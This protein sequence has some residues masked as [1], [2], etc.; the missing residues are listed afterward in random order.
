VRFQL[1]L[2]TSGQNKFRPK[3]RPQVTM[4]FPYVPPLDPP[5]QVLEAP[6]APRKVL[7]RRK[8]HVNTSIIDPSR[9]PGAIPGHSRQF[10]KNRFSTKI[11][12]FFRIRFFS[13]AGP[14]LREKLGIFQ[15]REGPNFR[16]RFFLDLASS[17]IDSEFRG[18][19]FEA[20]FG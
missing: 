2:A 20:V 1:I 3:F 8:K 13:S 4:G 18:L 19:S 16:Y 5:F 10:W 11:S 14:T 7:A 9:P 15:S 12:L 6:P 17:P